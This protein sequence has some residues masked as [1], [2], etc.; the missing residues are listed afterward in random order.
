MSAKEPL[1]LSAVTA[2]IEEAHEETSGVP[3]HI[4]AWSTQWPW[5]CLCW[6]VLLPCSLSRAA[7]EEQ[8]YGS[9]HLLVAP[10]SYL[11]VC[12]KGRAWAP[13][14]PSEWETGWF[15]NLLKFG[16]PRA[17]CRPLGIDFLQPD[18]PGPQHISRARVW[19]CSRHAPSDLRS[20]WLRVW[21]TVP[22]S[23][24]MVATAPWE[25]WLR[26][27][28]GHLH[29]VWPDIRGRRQKGLFFLVVQACPY[30][31]PLPPPLRLWWSSEQI[32]AQKEFSGQSLQFPTWK[33]ARAA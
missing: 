5:C 24:S 23:L 25:L 22:R 1:A 33:A 8:A 29:V 26:W 32:Q 28:A 16:N 17:N 31:L 7:V 13:P 6:P 12:E 27:V 30:P 11:K 2:S 3:R 14:R 10:A 21:S 20:I 18:C 9:P 15:W 19:T 4:L